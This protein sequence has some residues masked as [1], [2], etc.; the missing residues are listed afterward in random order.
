MGNPQTGAGMM[1]VKTREVNTRCT[2]PP[3]MC[4]YPEHYCVRVYRNNRKPSTTHLNSIMG[5]K[6][7]ARNGEKQRPII[8]ADGKTVHFRRNLGQ[9]AQCLSDTDE[10]DAIN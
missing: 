9:N 1:R 5:R 7:Y 6:P 3:M 10:P 8:D 4:S 2:K